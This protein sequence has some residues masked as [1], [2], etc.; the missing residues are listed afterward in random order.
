MFRYY[1]QVVTLPP[2]KPE[3]KAHWSEWSSWSN[4]ESSCIVGAKGAQVI[5]EVQKITYFLR[6]AKVL[7]GIFTR[8]PDL[9]I[10][11]IS[12]YI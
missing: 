9:P 7:T 11:I 8:V 10:D 3:A 12:A 5:I 1:L 2:P 6:S 4:C